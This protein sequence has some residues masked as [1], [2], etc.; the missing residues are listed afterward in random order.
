M[1]KPTG[2]MEYTR[3]TNPER[4][5]DERIKDYFEFHSSLDAQSDS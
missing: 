1:G 3:H 2:F 4:A 5:I